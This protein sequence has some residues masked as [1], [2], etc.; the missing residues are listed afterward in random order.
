MAGRYPMLPSTW[1]YAPAVNGV[2]TPPSSRLQIYCTGARFADKAR[3]VAVWSL[4]VVATFAAGP[5]NKLCLW[6]S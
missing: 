5:P 6:C 1:R 2:T 3:I 4:A